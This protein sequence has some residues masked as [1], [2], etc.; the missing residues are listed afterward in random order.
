MKKLLLCAG[1]LLAGYAAYALDALV[2]TPTSGEPVTFIFDDKPEVSFLAGKLQIVTAKDDTPVTFDI[3]DIAAIS[4]DTTSGTDQLPAA[5][6]ICCRSN[7]SEITFYNIPA[8]T[9][10][11]VYTATGMQVLATVAHD[12]LTLDRSA[13]ASGVYIVKIGTFTAKIAL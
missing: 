1:M 10:A 7:A 8:G 4:F 9:P 11:A 12:T 13:F 3:D 5:S 6:T 2:V